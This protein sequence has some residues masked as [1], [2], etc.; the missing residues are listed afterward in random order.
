LLNL[1]N[2]TALI[3]VSGRISEGYQ[4]LAI[5]RGKLTG[6]GVS[7]L[8]DI[9]TFKAAGYED[10]FFARW[11]GL[12]ANAVSAEQDI[13]AA[14]LF[15]TAFP[16]V[17][18]A[19]TSAAVLTLGGGQVMQGTLTMGSLVALQ[20]LAVSFAGPVTT[21]THLGMGIQDV[22]SHT[23]RIDDVHNQQ[24]DE[25]TSK[26]DA[27]ATP[28]HLPGGSVRLEGVSFGYLPLEPPLIEAFDLEVPAGS[29]VALVGASGS[30][31]STLGRI[32]AGL[33]RP[34]A[35]RLL[36]DGI[37]VSHWPAAALAATRAHV[38]QE[39]VLFEGSVRDNL[40][41]WD[42]SIPDAAIA[43]AAQ[44]AVIHDVISARPGGYGAR[45]EQE[46]R[47]FSG[48][49]RQRLEIARALATDP[50]ILVLD[51]ATSHLDSESE[52]LIQEA[53]KRVMAG[54]TS[55]VIAHRLS[56]ILAADLI[57]VMD[58]GRI[59]E[60]GTHDELLAFN[61]LYAQLYETQFKREKV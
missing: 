2:L 37:E 22:R 11:A 1:L 27:A 29:R 34:S 24:L 18:A 14:S 47:N 26:A 52:A 32:I 23:A 10:S 42:A 50:R 61:G 51:E 39:I 28:A 31:K 3:A 33:N 40:S 25:V 12:H 21:L 4:K 49:Q 16:S 30:G 19:L 54:R 41:L 20:S 45:V 5:E 6:V 56:T 17:S 44:D 59:V 36:F 58:R 35:G 43:R 13:G 7:G 46:G 15:A 48:G 9:E 8:Q 53:L 57:L 60:R 55:V 38:D